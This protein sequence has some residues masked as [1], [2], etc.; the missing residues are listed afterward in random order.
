MGSGVA[1]R[2]LGDFSV[3]RDGSE[4]PLPQSRK[5]RALIAYLAVVNKPQRRERPA[6]LA[7]HA[8]GQGVRLRILDRA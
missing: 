7:R 6:V 4:S 8:P 5:T 2:V 1:I 3:T